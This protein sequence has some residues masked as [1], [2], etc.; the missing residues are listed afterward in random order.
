MNTL[1]IAQGFL[2][3]LSS[4]IISGDDGNRMWVSWV[5]ATAFPGVLSL[6]PQTSDFINKNDDSCPVGLVT[7]KMILNDRLLQGVL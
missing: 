7:L 5:Q 6:W 2:L 3:A 4:E 1:R